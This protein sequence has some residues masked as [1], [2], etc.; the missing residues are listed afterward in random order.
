MIQFRPQ[1]ARDKKRIKG[2]YKQ[3]DDIRAD[4]KL[5]SDEKRDKIN[6]LLRE[7]ER[8]VK[9]SYL[10]Y[11]VSSGTARINEDSSLSPSEK[12]TAIK[13]LEDHYKSLED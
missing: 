10:R 9:A 11:K 12:A 5:T 13:N 4:D 1:I 8:I 7:R 3:A 6:V 2:L